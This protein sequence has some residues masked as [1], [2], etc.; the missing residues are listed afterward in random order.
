MKLDA[1]L[2][3]LQRQLQ[4][5]TANELGDEG[6]I[7]LF[8][9]LTAEFPQDQ[10]ARV[11]KGMAGADII[12]RVFSGGVFTQRSIIY[13]CK[14]HKRW[15]NRFTTKLREDQ[16]VAQADHAVLVSTVF[17]ADTRQLLVRDGVI[18][19]SPARIIAVAHMLRRQVLQTSALN[20][21]NADRDEKTA[22]LYEFM[23]SDRASRWD[24]MAQ[25]TTDLL[26]IEKSDAVWQE[27]TRTKRT[28]L[29]HAVQS[30]YDGFTGDI[31]RILASTEAP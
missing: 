28:G 6:E 11:P 24:R 8:E 17:P 22:R 12:Q 31:D 15:Q 16:I 1:Q 26:D 21:S 7:D 18:V 27:K 29:I 2:A 30:V 10:I 4:R 19:A 20:L 23:T 5:R 25:A 13:D 14:N 3:D 9:A